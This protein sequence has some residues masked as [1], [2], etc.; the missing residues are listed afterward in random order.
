MHFDKSCKKAA[1]RVN[2]M[3]RIRN[4]LTSDAAEAFYR[5]IFTNCNTLSLGLP[6]SRLKKIQSIEKRGKNITASALVMNMEI[7]IPSVSSLT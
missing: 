4:S 3:R 1:S 6:D 2:M 7:R 5:T